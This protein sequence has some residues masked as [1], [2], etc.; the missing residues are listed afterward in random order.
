MAKT[1]K[2]AE[3]ANHI[4]EFLNRG[5]YSISPHKIT[6]DNNQQW[7]IFDLNH[8]EVGI[9]SAS[10]VWIRRSV[11]DEWVCIARPCT[12]SGAI[13]AVEFLVSG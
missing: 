9:D 10:G 12:V 1:N 2:Q 13:Q 4:Q 5:G 7:V 3:A 11:K 8:R 6:L